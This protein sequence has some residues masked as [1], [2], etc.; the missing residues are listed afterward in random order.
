MSENHPN[1][2]TSQKLSNPLGLLGLNSFHGLVI[3]SGKVELIDSLAFI[4]FDYKNVRSSR[5]ENL[6]KKPY[7]TWPTAAKTLKK[8][9]DAAMRT[10]KKSQIIFRRH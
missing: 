2:L 10:Y 4:L 7:R 5:L 1:I 8:Y 6:Y 9:Q 3:L